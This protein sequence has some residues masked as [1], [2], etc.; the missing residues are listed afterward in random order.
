MKKKLFLTFIICLLLA[1]IPVLLI[2]VLNDGIFAFGGD[3]M[4]QQYEFYEHVHDAIL[5][6]NTMWDS[7]TDLGANLIGSYSFYL[8]GSPFFWVTLLFPSSFIPYLIGPLLVLKIALCGTFA[9]LFLSRYVK[10]QFY[11]M[12]GGILYAFCSFS[13]VNIFYNHFHEAILIFPLLLYSFD[14]LM[15]DDQKGLFAITVSLSAIM[16]YYFFVGQVVFVVIYFFVGVFTKRYKVT[17]KKFLTI[18]IE[19]VLGFCMALFILLPSILAVIQV[20]RTGDSVGFDGFNALFFS[21]NTYGTILSS[22]FLPA[23]YQSS[24]AY[25][26]DGGRLSWGSLA[27]WIPLFGCTGVFAYI[28][29]YK[30]HWITKLITVL[31]CF[32]CIPVLNSLF[33]MLHNDL[34][35]RWTYAFSLI[36]IL[37]TVIALDSV[38]K[39][40][41][42][43]A[44]R[45]SGLFIF[46][47]SAF[48]LLMP[49]TV[50]DKNYIGTTNFSVEIFI[51][52][53]FAIASFFLLGIYVY[54]KIKLNTLIIISCVMCLLY[55]STMSFVISIPSTWQNNVYISSI[56]NGRNNFEPLSD[57]NTDRY[58][59]YKTLYNYGIAYNVAHVNSF[60]SV[61][62]CSIFDFYNAIGVNRSVNTSSNTDQYGTDAL[63]SVR[64]LVTGID[65]S[66]SGEELKSSESF[67]NVLN[68]WRDKPPFYNSETK[69]TLISGY[70]YVGEQNGLYY[71]EN[72]NF[73]PIGF[74]Y[75]GYITKDEF[76][77]IPKSG[78]HLALAQTLVLDN[79]I[80][81][82][83]N[84][85]H[86]KLS[87]L[88]YDYDSYV[89]ACKSLKSN[90]CT[91]QKYVEN[92][93]VANYT[94]DSND[95]LFLSIPYESGWTAYVNGSQ[96]DIEKASFGF[97]CI[98]VNAGKND[99]KLIYNTPGL[100]IGIIVSIVSLAVFCAYCIISI[101]KEKR[102]RAF[103]K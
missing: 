25:N 81:Q 103:V 10:N 63:L 89:S 90:C 94:S 32:M 2:S 40:V 14:R 98:P 43:K 91:N 72:E 87:D 77:K 36:I 61:L 19:G 45:L 65:P 33:Q 30:K 35:F 24:N 74:C 47:V 3:F 78:K 17:V 39:T 6:G 5:S 16:N 64:Y 23:A 29:S 22:M 99:I 34:Y 20:P 54:K 51:Y 53:G 1:G 12:L 55:Q 79:D 80:A 59:T 38:E 75:N 48:V 68:D 31:F 49:T 96:V 26:Y 28:K 93:F 76:D 71:F 70:H 42:K 97:M 86:I 21:P 44:W 69:K 46:A 92:G 88:K 56:I 95:L 7:Q 73:V 27:L 37:A 50:K 41:W 52:I 4:A 18:V 8:I 83:Y 57:N 11:A 62:P 60:H 66:S 67:Y 82:K 84:I 85:N 15:I 102:R 13:T 58:N 9:H 101:K 100:N